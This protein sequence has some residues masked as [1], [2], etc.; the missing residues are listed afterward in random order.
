MVIFSLYFPIVIISFF[1]FPS[2]ARKI[3]IKYLLEY[4]L[5]SHNLLYFLVEK[6]KIT[7]LKKEKAISL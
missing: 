1:K 2:V 5:L 4:L 7:A 3:A 6:R